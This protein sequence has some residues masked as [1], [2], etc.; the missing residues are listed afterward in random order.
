LAYQGNPMC[1]C[2]MPELHPLTCKKA[3]LP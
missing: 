1:G 3:H 2:G